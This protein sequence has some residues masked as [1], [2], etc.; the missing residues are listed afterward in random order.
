MGHLS[1]NCRLLSFWNWKYN[2]VRLRQQLGLPVVPGELSDF[3]FKFHFFIIKW[4]MKY[5]ANKLNI[6]KIGG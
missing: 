2:T 6:T 4:G 3:F 5:I 1:G